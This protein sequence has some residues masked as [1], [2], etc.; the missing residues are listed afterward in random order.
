MNQKLSLEQ[1]A[2]IQEKG[3]RILVLAGAGAG[4]TKTI[5]EKIITL[6]QKEKVKPYEIMAITFTK[7]A[8]NEM[9][10]RLLMGADSTGEYKIFLESKHTNTEQKR[11]RR[12]QEKKKHKWINQLTIRTFHSLCYSVLRNYGAKEFDNKFRLLTDTTIQAESQ[13]RKLTAPESQYEILHKLLIEQCADRSFLLHFKKFILDYLVDR[14]HLPKKANLQHYPH[15][16]YYTSLR[17]EMI[18]S[19]SEQYICDWLYRHSIDY[20]Y[21]PNLVI[22]EITL[23]PDF[24]IP[25]ANIY[26]E[27][28]S[29]K[30]G[31]MDGKE[32]LFEKGGRTLAQTFEYMMTDSNI[33]NSALSRIVKNRLPGN[34]EEVVALRY[35]EEMKGRHA[36]VRNFLRQVVRVLEICQSDRVDLTQ[37]KRKLK[38]EPHERIRMFYDCC[39][40]LIENYFDYCEN[41]SYLDFNQLVDKTIQLLKHQKDVSEKMHNQYKYVLIDEFQDVNPMQIDFIKSMMNPEAQLFCVGDDWQSIYGFR[42]SDIKYIV[43][44]NKYFK[45]G[46]IYSLSTNYRSSDQIV[47]ASN[48]VISNNNYQSHKDIKAYSKS[49][50][51]IQ[52]YA[53]TDLQDNVFYIISEI[54]ALIAK[55]IIEDE[56]LILYRRSK[57]FFPYRQALHKENLKVN[58]KT[59][60]GAKGLESKV[61]FVIG[62]TE[63]YGGFPD[64]WMGDRIYQVVRPVKYN[65]LM[66]E[67]RR[68]FYV[69]ITRAKEYLYLITELGVESSFIDEIPSEL[70][71]LYSTRLQMSHTNTIKCMNCHERLE[72]SYKFCPKCGIQQNN[73][74]IDDDSKC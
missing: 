23:R 17:G 6:I 65:I 58:A 8:A 7:N 59:I 16:K 45:D 60:H 73:L 69:A 55:G 26:L 21:E 3:A 39:I 31:S 49:N 64:I 38:A 46:K 67:E 54:K 63:G 57:M 42:G 13:Y 10:D 2:A 5:L 52:V 27:H 43:E 74:H 37:L 68:L 56:I 14:I 66:E 34:Y 25:K 30:S 11:I 15:G 4:K 48:Q 20:Q 29:E 71:A 18:R 70:K 41:K 9:I 19:K 51:K 33:I 47:S 22:E 12:I 24:Y 36:E 1:L 62:L 32:R 35:E 53:G 72:A 28:V 61:V 44:F 50:Q 40:P